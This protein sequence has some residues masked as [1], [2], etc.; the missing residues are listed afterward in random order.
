MDN[1]IKQNSDKNKI[2]NKIKELINET[3]E[4]FESKIK[5]MNMIIESI[6]IDHNRILS[7]CK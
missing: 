7:K 1:L 5:Q 6:K 4:L 2:K 3:N